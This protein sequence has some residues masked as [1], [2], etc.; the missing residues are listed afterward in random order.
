MS[1]ATLS[2]P[3][4]AVFTPAD[5]ADAAE[6]LARQKARWA[7]FLTA[8]DVVLGLC[9]RAMGGLHGQA[10][11]LHLTGALLAAGRGLGWLLGRVGAVRGALRT[12]GI[13]ASVAWGLTTAPGGRVVGSVLRQVGASVG[14]GAS[15]LYRG[16]LRGL[17]RLGSP[18]KAISRGLERGVAAVRTRSG[19]VQPVVGAV[20]VALAP[21]GPVVQAVHRVA[22]VRMVAAVIDRLLPRP[23]NVLGRVLASVLILPRP[24][25]LSTI[26]L[27]AGPAL[28]G[29][30]RA[31][32]GSDGP[33]DDPPPAGTVV[34]LDCRQ[35]DDSE[36]EALPM[37]VG[38]ESP[39]KHLQKYP[40]SRKRKTKKRR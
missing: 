9:H 34:L 17:G 12:P 14:R 27:L 4:Q 35:A 23:W 36:E 10:Q 30:S 1:A 22:R 13:A 6:A 32:E 31:G 16:L 24:A 33:E 21:A 19:R 2:P 5:A 15:W 28:A 11:R 7:Q 20:R 40:A 8:R 29:P 38:A 39:A 25:R 37:A 3:L 18:G 26:R